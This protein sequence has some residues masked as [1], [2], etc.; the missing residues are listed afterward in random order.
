MKVN[1]S[2][3]LL[4][5]LPLN[6]LL[7][8]YANSKNKPYITPHTP[9]T[10]SR[11]LNKCDINTSIYDDPDM[12]FVKEN[13]YR[14]TSQRFEEYEEHKIEKTLAEKVE[15]VCLMCACGLGGGVA[16]VWSLVSCLWYEKW[17]QYIIAKV[18][19]EAIDD[20]NEAGI[21]KA[22][23]GLGSLHELGKLV[24]DNWSNIVTPE[25]YSNPNLPSSALQWVNITMCYN[26]SNENVLFCNA[27]QQTRQ[28]VFV[29][30]SKV[31]ADADEAGKIAYSATEKSELL[32]TASATNALS[33]AII[34]SVLSIIVIVLVMVII[35]IIL[36]YI[37]EKKKKNE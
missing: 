25:T 34:S 18:L 2:K 4:F 30:A 7:S 19:E 11:V 33:T 21:A 17:S 36:R 23:E 12:K 8:S 9:N 16:P 1:Y 37:V 29:P 13:F 28:N 15:K 10:T 32:K 24:G 31:A 5:S 27:I 26:E 22:I 20:S 6:I 35:Y 3:I 14:Q